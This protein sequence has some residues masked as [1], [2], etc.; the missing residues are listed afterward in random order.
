[1]SHPAAAGQRFLATIPLGRLSTPADVA[2]ACLYLASDEA[3]FITGSY[4]PI[5][6]GYMAQ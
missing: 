3:S 2:A 5:D 1:M 4:Y 6:G